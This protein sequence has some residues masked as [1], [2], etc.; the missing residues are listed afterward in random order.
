V[1]DFISL[2]SWRQAQA[3]ANA[4]GDPE[5]RRIA[6][7]GLRRTR[8]LITSALERRWLGAALA[9]GPWLTPRVGQNALLWFWFNHFNVFAGKGLVGAALPIYLDGAISPFTLGRFE[10]LLLAVTRHPAMLVYLDNVSNF[11]N[12]RNEN[13]ARELLELHTLG[14]DGGYGQ[15]DVQETARLLTGFGLVPLTPIRWSAEVAGLAREEAEFLFDPR[16]HDF[17]DK[18]IL[19]RRFV[20]EGYGELP[21]LCQ[22]LSAQPATARHVSR[23]LATFML[24]DQVP[25]QALAAAEDAF[26]RTRGQIDLVVEALLPWREQ[27]VR[28]ARQMSFK[29]PLHWLLDAIQ[30]LSDGRPVED[31][32]PVQRWLAALGQPLFG[33][34]TPDGYPLEGRQWLGAGQ[35]TQR[36][37]TARAMVLTQDRVFSGRRTPQ[38]LW[39]AP[40]VQDALSRVGS[41]T[42]GA[43]QGA[44]L[45]AEKL[46]L[47]LVSPEFNHW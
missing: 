1:D 30:L 16:R 6:N 47:L 27:I 45:P 44:T 3:A 4:L 35:L 33:R 22:W 10:D 41:R 5:A 23:R 13:H 8:G 29:L 7:A 28:L 17:L 14:V 21:A 46:A 34:T 12:R 19:G 24:G 39:D 42:W 31:T 20:A 38:A 43:I 37:E 18:T 32:A 40:P 36:A 25:P 2:R 9:E 15:A 26:M 11:A